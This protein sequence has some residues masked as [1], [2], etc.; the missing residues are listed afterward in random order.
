[1]RK[2]LSPSVLISI[3]AIILASTGLA[4]A[5]RHTIE[6][7]LGGVD[8]HALSTKPHAD[9]ILLLGENRKFPAAAIPT[10]YEASHLDG[11]TVA[12]LEP[13]CP[14]SAANM[15]TWCLDQSVYPLPEKETGSDNWFYASR[16]CVELGGFLPSASQLIGAAKRVAL[17]TTVNDTF[18]HA[19]M[20]QTDTKNPA[21]KD[22]REMSSTLITTQGGA[23][24]A[25]SVV[26]PA[27][28]STQY[29]TVYSNEQKGG[30]AGGEPV[31][32]PENF[33]CAYYKSL[34]AI[35]NKEEL[36]PGLTT[37]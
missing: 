22:K 33:R 20:E 8:G 34:G 1:M 5:A 23:S 37:E 12:E 30:L 2:H 21:L 16:K 13:T 10:A 26:D 27:P 6:H 29:I 28:E 7:A 24:A 25:G 3:V 18:N 32:T 15:G 17:E 31:A 14:P 36:L 11:K 4:E 19:L 9:G 35:N